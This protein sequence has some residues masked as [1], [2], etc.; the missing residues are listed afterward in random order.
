MK[1]LNLKEIHEDNL[2]QIEKELQ[3]YAS[4]QNQVMFFELFDDK[5]AIQK[6]IKELS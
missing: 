1:K 4:T 5:I 3:Y 2:R 6:K